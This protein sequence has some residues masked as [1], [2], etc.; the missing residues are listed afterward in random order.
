MSYQH[1]NAIERHTLMF[2]HQMKVSNRE[3]GRRLGRCHTTIGRVIERNTLFDGYCDTQ[4][5]K[6]ASKRKQE[7]SH[8]QK[9]SNEVLKE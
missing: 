1:L 9:Q 7:P 3:I 8:K 4:A 5:Q 6:L 2:L